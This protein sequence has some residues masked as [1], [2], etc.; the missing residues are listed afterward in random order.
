MD[1]VR[2][3]VPGSL[4]YRDVVLR[5]I[6]SACRLVRP[7]LSKQEASREA[8]VMDFEAKVVSAVSEAFNNVAIHAYRGGPVGALELEVELESSAEGLTIRMLDMGVTFDPATR[9]PPNLAELPES[10]MGLYIMRACMDEVH[11]QPGDPPRSPNVLTLFKRYPAA[12][13]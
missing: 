6:A 4:R 8:E 3:S 9:E 11:Y 7:V 1:I 12:A 2:L 5:V 13:E 10:S